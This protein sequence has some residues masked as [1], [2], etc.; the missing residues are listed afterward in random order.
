M[1]AA[2]ST[3]GFYDV[4]IHDYIPDDAVEIS[5]EDHAALM[6]G[7]SQGL[8]IEWGDDGGLPVLVAP[9][10]P[11]VDELAVIERGWRD[12]QIAATD[13]LVARHRDEQEAGD[14]TTLTTE[15]YTELQV[16]RRQLRNWPQGEE[17]PLAEHR[18][19]APPWLVEQTT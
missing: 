6:A 3:R 18:P 10:L 4:L 7:Q 16:Y 2:K 11:S 13:G 17:F 12:A 14:D 9:Q 19:P 1:F 8:V 5:V 15:Q